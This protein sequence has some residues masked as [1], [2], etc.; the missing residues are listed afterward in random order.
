MD[1]LLS[2]GDQPHP[3]NLRR[4]IM[5]PKMMRPTFGLALSEQFHIFMA[6]GVVKKLV[7]PNKSKYSGHE[8]RD[9][10]GLG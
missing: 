2:V 1:I 4:L 3:M 7:M 10:P 6:E 9:L 8:A 5:T